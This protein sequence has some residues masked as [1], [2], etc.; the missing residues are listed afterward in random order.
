MNQ[1][2]QLYETQIRM[3]HPPKRVKFCGTIY[4]KEKM[5]DGDMRIVYEQD[6]FMRSRSQL[7]TKIENLSTMYSIYTSTKTTFISII[8]D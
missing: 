3:M 4:I 5:F 6:F 1:E 2:I 7:K 8:F